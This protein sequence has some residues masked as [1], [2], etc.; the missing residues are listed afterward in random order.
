M[1]KYEWRATESAPSGFPMEIVRGTLVFPDGSGLYIPDKKTI[2]H[3]WGMPV[4]SHVVGELKKPLPN[5]VEITYFSYAENQFYRGAFELPYEQIRALFERGYVSPST[6]S[7]TSYT[8]IMVGVTP[9]GG[10]AVWLYGIGRT[11][12]V[13]FEQAEKTDVDWALVAGSADMSRDEF[14]RLEMEDSIGAGGLAA[15]QSTP[16]TIDTWTKFHQ[17]RYSWQPQIVGGA[18]VVDLIREVRFVN[19]EKDFWILPS[20]AAGEQQTRAVPESMRFIGTRSGGE[21]YVHDVAFQGEE[22]QKAFHELSFAGEGAI[23]LEIELKVDSGDSGGVRLSVRNDEDA[24]ELKQSTVKIF[25]AV[26]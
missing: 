14:V 3:G 10:V 17:Q 8:K 18:V 24:I 22:I 7:Q 12:E 1:S 26:R 9:G 13:L 6:N 20:D 19:G 15:L 23:T 16:V 2:Y 11:T 5:R 25:P 21:R 4:S